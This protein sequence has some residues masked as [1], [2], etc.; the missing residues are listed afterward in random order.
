MLDHKPA[1]DHR[2]DIGDEP[3]SNRLDDMNQ[4]EPDECK[5]GDEVDGPGSLTPTQYRQE[6]GN[7]S[8][9][10]RRHRETGQHDQWGHDKR[11]VV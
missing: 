4:N 3:G 2:A 9:D 10:R 1:S 7:C 8:V 5:T 11:M 6:P